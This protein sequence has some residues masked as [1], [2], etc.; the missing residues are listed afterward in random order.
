MAFIFNN[1]EYRNKR[2]SYNFYENK[3]LRLPTI[4]QLYIHTN[5]IIDL[6]FTYYYYL[7]VISKR[8]LSIY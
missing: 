5:N 6:Q 4:I 8:K 3:V 1:I 7:S 2:H